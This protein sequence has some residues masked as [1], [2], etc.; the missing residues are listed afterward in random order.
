MKGKLR[1]TA[2]VALASL[3]LVS[4][5]FEAA[6]LHAQPR[7]Q[8]NVYDATVRC[9]GLAEDSMAHVRLVEFDPNGGPNGEPLIEF[10]CKRFGY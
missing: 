2:L 5:S 3:A 9:P 6:A 1:Q 8:R 4:C 7:P 10:H